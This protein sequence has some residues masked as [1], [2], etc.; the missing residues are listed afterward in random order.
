MSFDLLAPHYTWMETILAGPRL[1]Q[2]RVA[3]LDALA[4]RENILIAGVGHGHFLRRCAIRFPSAR[5]TSVDASREMLDHAEA[6]ARRAGARMDR[7]N[8]V[9]A[10]LPAWQPPEPEFDAIVTHFFLDCFRPEELGLVIR[11]LAGGAHPNACWLIGDF[12]VPARGLA[13]LRARAL[14]TLMYAFFRLATRIRADRVTEP[15][16]LLAAAGFEL[17]QRRT[18]EWGLL[19]SD[20]WLRSIATRHNA[21]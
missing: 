5:V 20:L 3:W 12:A 21:S 13:R 15:D 17:F 19:R 11:K 16:A 1:Q 10:T 8:F 9:H 7:L 14:H 18:T 4:G 6:G 2:S